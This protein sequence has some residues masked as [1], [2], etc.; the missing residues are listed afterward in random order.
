MLNNPYLQNILL[1]V[2]T[3]PE[4]I[5]QSHHTEPIHDSEP[6]FEGKIEEESFDERDDS[7]EDGNKSLMSKLNEEFKSLDP[8]S[9]AIPQN[10]LL[11]EDFL[12]PFNKSNQHMMSNQ[13]RSNDFELSSSAASQRNSDI[14]IE[15][16]DQRQ[17][18]NSNPFDAP[19]HGDIQQELTNT[20]HDIDQEYKMVFKDTDNKFYEQ[21]KLKRRRS[22]FLDLFRDWNSE[23]VKY[24]DLVN[25]HFSWEQRPFNSK[26]LQLK[27]TCML[28]IFIFYFPKV[29]THTALGLKIDPLKDPNYLKITGKFDRNIFF[30]KY[31][32]FRIANL[33]R[34][35]Y[36]N[37]EE[38]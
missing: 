12:N 11:S 37:E 32:N 30:N 25:L 28:N 18:Q 6:S 24:A 38:E 27:S 10:N 13:S 33:L 34:E 16:S 20:S 26:I 14:E 21:L 9:K 35:Y 19:R 4:I 3:I 31:R 1:K 36:P 2:R 15:S 8:T 29:L 23:N 17:D 22:C 5:K 7:E